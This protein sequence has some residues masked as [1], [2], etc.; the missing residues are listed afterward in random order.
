MKTAQVPFILA[1]IAATALLP[2]LLAA[3][4][5]A[6]QPSAPASPIVVHGRVTHHHKGVA[7]ARVVLYATPP[8]AEQMKHQ[9]RG[10]TVP[11]RRI[12]TATTSKRGYYAIAVA[13]AGLRQARA[14]AFGKPLV[15]NLEIAAYVKHVGAARWF[16]RT[17]R[18]NTLAAMNVPAAS[19]LATA[20]EVANLDIPDS[21]P[22][23]PAYLRSSLKPGNPYY[24]DAHNYIRSLGVRDTVVGSTYSNMRNV[25]MS[26]TYTRGADSSLG[27]S[28]S[29]VPPPGFTGWDPLGY[30]MTLGGQSSVTSTTTVPY[31]PHNGFENDQYKTGFV[32]GLSFQECVGGYTQSVSFAG[33]SHDAAVPGFASTNRW[34]KQ[35]NAVNKPVALDDQAAYA[36]TQGVDIS[37]WLDFNLSSQTGYSSTAEADYTFPKG[38]YLCGTTNYAVQGGA[39]NKI[40]AGKYHHSQRK[41]AA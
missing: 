34:C 31:T 10:Y 18:L 35:Y 14:Y 40:F 1:V 27:L 33:G 6:A 16:S 8:P 28:V 2:A 25:K 7:N 22:A 24:C 21:V 12:G 39:G 17:V 4:A 3:P 13:G 36:F 20:P 37:A 26:F 15:V 23:A 29:I 38:G 11:M 5:G 19:P 41:A 30:D 32:Y 9:H